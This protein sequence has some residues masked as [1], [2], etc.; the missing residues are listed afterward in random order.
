MPQLLSA[1]SKRN[2]HFVSKSST[3]PFKIRKM[4]MD[5]GGIVNGS[6]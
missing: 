6:A 5:F 4:L 1:V 2:L 3:V